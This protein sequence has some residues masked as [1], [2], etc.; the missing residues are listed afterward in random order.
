MTQETMTLRGKLLAGLAG[1]IILGFAATASAHGLAA[2]SGT[3]AAGQT[4][5]GVQVAV[6]GGGGP[7]SH[8]AAHPERYQRH[9]RQWY[10]QQLWRYYQ[11]VREQP[12]RALGALDGRPG[13]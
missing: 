4:L 3:A 11:P 13:A 10:Y 12:V 2:S 8:A 6:S 5:Q 9:L 7:Y 1:S